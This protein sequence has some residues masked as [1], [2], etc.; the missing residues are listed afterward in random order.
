M[1]TPRVALVTCAP[2][3][4][5]DDD[6]PAIT[7]AL[8]ARGLEAAVERWDD[9]VDWRDYDLVVIRSTWD[10]HDRLDD[11]LVWAE[12]VSALTRLVNPIEAIRVNHDKRYLGRLAEA[13]VPTVP[14]VYVDP[15]E[16][17]DR[18]ALPAAAEYVVKPT[19]SAGS[20][21][22]FRA[23]EDDLEAC[24]EAV[25]RRDKTAMVQ[26]YVDSVD[27]RGETGLLFF[28][29]AYSHAFTKG[30]MLSPDRRGVD[31]ASDELYLAE[32][33]APATASDAEHQAA[34]HCLAALPA[35]GLDAAALLY[36][37]VDLV[38]D[39]EQTVRLMELELIE[40]SLFLG[41]DPDAA[42]RFAA[43]VGTAL[44]G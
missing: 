11:F 21:N 37:R 38:T 19:V 29:G 28:G 22:T 3:P 42:G 33:I 6:E 13:G 34:E 16:Q 35:L 17:L 27:Q 5:I 2:G 18:S 41:T 9:E 7:E 30:A 4:G 39:A 25:H 23:T 43:A 1:T 44:R 24:V 15:G 40:P 26:P 12:R 31:G 10:Y 32:Q 14:T 20:Q 8:Q 36:A